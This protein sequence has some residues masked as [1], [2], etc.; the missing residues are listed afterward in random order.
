LPQEPG[1]THFSKYSIAPVRAITPVFTWP[2]SPFLD[3]YGNDVVGT[4]SRLLGSIKKDFQMD[5]KTKQELEEMR[6]FLARQ[7]DSVSKVI[8]PDSGGSIPLKP[9]G[10]AFPEVMKVIT[11]TTNAYVNVVRTLEN[12]KG[13]V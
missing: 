6:D 12:D 7:F 10:K 3:T 13:F 1:F 2:E 5:E 9:N 4:F 8:E 11:D